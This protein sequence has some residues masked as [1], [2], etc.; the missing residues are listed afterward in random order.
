MQHP[1]VARDT[2]FCLDLAYPKAPQ[3]A[4]EYD[5]A[6]HRTQRRARRDLLREATL[7]A[8][9]WRILRFDADVVLFRP[10]RIVT[11]VRAELATRGVA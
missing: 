9:G 7:T 5:S 3:V 4:L 8:L 2:C 10:E 6:E 1:V 11:V